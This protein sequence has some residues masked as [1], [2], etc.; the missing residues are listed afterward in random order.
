MALN[1]IVLDELDDRLSEYSANIRVTAEGETRIDKEIEVQGYVIPY[2][3][4]AEQGEF[5][6]VNIERDVSVTKPEGE[7]EDFA[8][9]FLSYIKIHAR[10]L[11]IANSLAEDYVRTTQVTLSKPKICRKDDD[12]CVVYQIKE[13]LNDKY[14]VVKD[15][16]SDGVYIAGEF[17]RVGK[18]S[19]EFDDVLTARG[20]KFDEAEGLTEISDEYLQTILAEGKEEEVSEEPV[21]EEVTTGIESVENA[22]NEDADD[23]MLNATEENEEGISDG[24]YSEETPVED[25]LDEDVDDV[26][27]EEL[28][29]EP[30]IEE[31]TLEE[32]TIEEPAIE[33]P[34]EEAIEEAIE[35]EPVISDESAV[36]DFGES[37]PSIIVKV[38]TD[39]DNIEF[40]RFVI[41]LNGKVIHIKDV[42]CSKMIQYGFTTDRIEFSTTEYHKCGVII[43]EDVAR[44]GIIRE[45]VEDEGEIKEL[46]DSV[47]DL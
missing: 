18:S 6:F 3:F 41:A 1:G 10:L 14:Y 28:I 32:P 38:F 46:V 39:I 43:D 2:W 12:W 22:L 33:E 31:S 44:Y 5:G 42:V 47:I 36:S 37:G 9:N 29:E 24:G 34:I 8:L 11:P 17:R 27:V 21:E 16:T 45:I 35:E 19:T 40:I 20:F 30:T 23:S 4:D 25:I 13:F 26:P 7:F 15:E